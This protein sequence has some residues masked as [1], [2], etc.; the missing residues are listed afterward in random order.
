MSDVLRI[1]SWSE[2]PFTSY[3]RR[4]ATVEHRIVA[5]AYPGVGADI[6]H[7][8]RCTDSDVG[9]EDWSIAEKYEVRD[10]GIRRL[11]TSSRWWA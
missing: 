11:E 3:E 9:P 8:V 4:G 6:R 7:E 5:E 10:H 1:A 2:R